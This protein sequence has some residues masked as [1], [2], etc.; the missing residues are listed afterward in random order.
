MPAIASF[1]ATGS[2]VRAQA[3]AGI[4]T[5]AK[6][7]EKQGVRGKTAAKSAAVFAG[8]TEDVQE[9]A[10]LLA[11]LPVKIRQALMAVGDVSRDGN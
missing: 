5:T 7:P 3:R 6:N 10:A 1:G 8:T 9:L 11:K 2:G 4:E